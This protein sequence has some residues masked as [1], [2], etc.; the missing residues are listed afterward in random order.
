MRENLVFDGKRT[1]DDRATQTIV[2]FDGVCN[3]CNSAVNFLIDHDRT[4]TLLFTSFQSPTGLRLLAEHGIT[5][6]PETIYVI[7][8]NMLYCE[9]AAV[10][11]LAKFLQ[12][13]WLRFCAY[14]GYILPR[15]IR[16]ALYRVVARNRYRWFG[17]RDTCRLPTA[18]EYSRFL[19]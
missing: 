4:G 2:V 18:E 12:P 9:S 8:A 11:V 19:G 13:W 6:A 3:L 17:K 7:H 14:A 16:D 15:F 1:S 5:T 10:L